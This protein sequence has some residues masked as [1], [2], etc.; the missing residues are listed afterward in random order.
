M[1]CHKDQFG[2]LCCFGFTVMI[3]ITLVINSI[4]LFADNTNLMTDKTLDQLHIKV[5]TELEK[6]ARWLLAKKN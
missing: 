1:E 4:V 3:L 2:D 6:I 5:N